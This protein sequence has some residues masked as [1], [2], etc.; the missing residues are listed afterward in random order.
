M[1][2]RSYEHSK[3]N[4]NNANSKIKYSCRVVPIHMQDMF[5]QEI[6]QSSISKPLLCRNDKCSARRT[7]PSLTGNHTPMRRGH[8]TP[9]LLTPDREKLVATLPSCGPDPAQHFGCEVFADGFPLGST[10]ASSSES[11]S[12]R[13]LPASTYVVHASI[14]PLLTT[15]RRRL[16]QRCGTA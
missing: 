14:S 12:H 2:P 6:A 7:L 8:F 11:S 5:I 16:S 10:S 4:D 15:R 13:K 3:S 9:P 1:S